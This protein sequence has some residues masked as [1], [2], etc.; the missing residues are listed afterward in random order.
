MK[1]IGMKSLDETLPD[2]N[3]L[4]EELERKMVQVH[5]SEWCLLNDTMCEKDY[6]YKSEILKILN[7]VISANVFR[8]SVYVGDYF[9]NFKDFTS[10]YSN[11]FQCL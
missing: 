7:P 4:F 10:M 9:I 11:L 6:Y 1:T 3:L 2:F 5:H 8:V